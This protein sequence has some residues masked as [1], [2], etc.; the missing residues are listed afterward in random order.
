MPI[1]YFYH[2]GDE[3]N[4]QQISGEVL[5]RGYLQSYNIIKDVRA[6]TNR[7][8]IDLSPGSPAY[9]Y[10]VI[11]PGPPLRSHFDGSIPVCARFSAASAACYF[12][13]FHPAWSRIVWQNRRIV[14]SDVCNPARARDVRR[15]PVQVSELA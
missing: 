11:E 15:R 12:R 3:P 10:L 7:L 13:K 14:V 4:P 1:S 9:A 6:E 5:F 8:T 2:F